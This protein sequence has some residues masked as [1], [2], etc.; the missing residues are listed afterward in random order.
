MVVCQGLSSSLSAAPLL[1]RNDVGEVRVTVGEVLEEG[2]YPTLQCTTRNTL[3]TVQEFK[4]TVHPKIK[5]MFSSLPVALFIHL[6]LASL[7]NS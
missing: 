1:K 3:C 6:D 2:K 7:Q 4:G 5:N